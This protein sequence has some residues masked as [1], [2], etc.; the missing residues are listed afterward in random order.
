LSSKI[1]RLLELV[2]SK[3][4]VLQSESQASVA[5]S[6]QSVEVCEKLTSAIEKL[7]GSVQITD[8]GEADVNYV[9]ARFSQAMSLLWTCQTELSQLMCDQKTDTR[10]VTIVSDQDKQRS[11]DQACAI[12]V[13]ETRLDLAQ[14][15]ATEEVRKREILQTELTRLRELVRS[16]EHG[17]MEE[18]QLVQDEA[19]QNVD[20]IRRELELVISTARR[21]VMQAESDL[22]DREEEMKSMV[23]RAITCDAGSQCADLSPPSELSLQC[24]SLQDQL[25]DAAAELEQK[26]L[27][28]ATLQEEVAV[29]ES[30]L[31][32]LRKALEGVHVKESVV[33]WRSSYARVRECSTDKADIFV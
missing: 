33:S 21:H 24:S 28:I 4:P 6:A 11:Q 19:R 23:Y 10:A 22:A 16:I 3:Q 27:V 14:Q 17:R 26:T 9:L 30:S 15:L 20:S 31:L 32:E 25:H 7:E 29:R 8:S 5:I 18:T 2:L 12:A 1:S 13:A